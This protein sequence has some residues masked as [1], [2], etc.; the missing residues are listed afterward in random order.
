M[1]LVFLT[2]VFPNPFEPTKGTFNLEMVR[3]L[4]EDHSIEVLSPVSWLDELR[5]SAAE[6]PFLP[7]RRAW[8]DGVE[9]CYPRF[10]YTPKILRSCYGW[11]MWQSVSGRLLRSVRTNPP[12]AIL[13]YWAHPDG[14][15]ALRAARCIGKPCVIMVGG[16]DVLLLTSRPSRRRCILE[17][18]ANA[19]AVIAVS[20]DIKS[21]LVTFGIDPAKV[22][23]VYR[24]VDTKRFAPGDRQEARRRLGLPQERPV[25]LWVGRMV[26]VKRLDVLLDACEILRAR[27]SDIRVALVGAGPLEKS[28]KTQCTGRSLEDIVT[29]AGSAAHSDLPDWYQAADLL[30][31]PSQSEGVPNV[32]LESMACGT[33]FVASRVGGIPEIATPGLD[34]LVEAADPRALADGVQEKLA[35]NG[36]PVER[37]FFPGSWSAVAQQ[38]TEVIQPLTNGSTGSNGETGR[39]L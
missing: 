30:V 7:G 21:K 6:P 31:L 4:Q 1:R 18:L 25:L 13:T 28:L 20:R 35:R 9:A 26:P 2:N 19:D 15:V 36:P 27:R 16:S 38:L 14:Y 22:H 37:R 33:P 39:R 8:M 32:L 3:A 5:A 24:G 34:R 23:V 11:F 10:Y 17:V 12:H 29:F